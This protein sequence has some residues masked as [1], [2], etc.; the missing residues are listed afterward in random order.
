MMRW[1]DAE[2]E[3]EAG[4]E[5]IAKSL[6]RDPSVP[7]LPLITRTWSDSRRLAGGLDRLIRFD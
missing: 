3:M 4:A 6:F 5:G 1:R 7:G 2:A